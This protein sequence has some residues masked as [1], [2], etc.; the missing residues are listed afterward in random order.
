MNVLTE[1]TS[2]FNPA[3]P[4]AE[5]IRN[6]SVLVLA[7]TG[8]YFHCGPKE[9]S[10]IPSFASGAGPRPAPPFPPSER[11]RVGGA[12]SSRPRSTGASRLRSPGRRAGALVVFVLV[13]VSARINAALGGERPAAAGSREGDNTLFV[14]VVGCQWWWEY[15]YD[16]YNGRKLAFTTA[17]E[18]HIPAGEKGAPRPVYLT[19]KSAD[20]CHSFWVPRWGGKPD[21]IP[22]R[23]NSMWLQTGQARPATSGSAQSIAAPSTPTCSSGSSSIPRATSRRGW[24]TSAS[25]PWSAP[26]CGPGWP[27]S[28]AYRASTVIGCGTPARGILCGGPDPRH[29]PQDIGVRRGRKHPRKPACHWVAD[30]QQ[31]KPGC[32]MP[33]FG[34][35]DRGVGRN[36][37]AICGRSA[38]RV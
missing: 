5:S 33:A 30:P 1:G 38:D 12:R 17:N 28:C 11:E 18:L 14:T 22:G 27:P 13:L 2:I 16:R 4:A 24:P 25:R 3:A 21:L 6:L 9:S 32:L 19:F 29:E 8:F 35:R 31:I 7:I 36:R 23:T 26:T 34:L 10:S 20:V 15:T 37:P